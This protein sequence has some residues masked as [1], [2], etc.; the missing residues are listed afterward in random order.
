VVFGSVQNSCEKEI[1]SFVT[2]VNPS[3]RENS[4]LTGRILMAFDIAEFF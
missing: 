3:A 2:S 4:A 1:I